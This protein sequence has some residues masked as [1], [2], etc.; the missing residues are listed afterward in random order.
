MLRIARTRDAGF[1]TCKTKMKLVVRMEDG[2]MI[3]RNQL[4][5]I[6]KLGIG[7]FESADEVKR[8]QDDL[9]QRLK[10]NMWFRNRSNALAHCTTDH[11]GSAKCVEVCAF[12]DWRRRLEEIPAAYRL[13]KEATGPIHEVRVIRGLWARPIGDLHEVSVAAAREL[14]RRALNRLHKKPRTIQPKIRKPRRYPVWLIPHMFGNRQQ[15][16]R[17]FTKD[18][19]RDLPDPRAQPLDLRRR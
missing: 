14:N 19:Q 9:V 2:H 1:T 3:D 4:R 17:G 11:C 10:A 6:T 18:Q 8:R 13:L 12:A 5:R 15:P 7:D 16:L